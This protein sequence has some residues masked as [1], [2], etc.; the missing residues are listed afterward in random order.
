MG[1]CICMFYGPVKRIYV[2]SYIREGYV[3]KGRRSEGG[4]T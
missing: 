3:L 1:G 2:A 4:G